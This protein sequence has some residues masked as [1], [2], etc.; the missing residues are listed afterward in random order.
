MIDSHCHLA[1][2]EFEADLPEVIARAKQAGGDGGRR[3]PGRAG[4][5]RIAAM[6]AGP[7]A[8]PEARAAVGVHPHQ[9]GEFA[10]DPAAAAR[11]LACGS[12][13][14]P[15]ARAV[16]EI[17]LDYHYDF[18]PREVQQAVFRAQLRLA[19][20]PRPAGRDP[21]PRGRRRHASASS[22]GIAGAEP[23]GVFHCFTG[24]STAAARAL[25]TGF[26]LSIPGIVTFPKAVEL[27]E[28]VADV[29]ADR[30]L[31]ET[32]SPY[33]APIPYPRQAQRAGLRRPGGRESLA[34]RA[35]GADA[36]ATASRRQ[37]RLRPTSTRSV[38]SRERPQSSA[39][40]GLTRLRAL[41]P[42][43]ALW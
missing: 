2:E 42:A 8:W 15:G 27:R 33:L 31:V 35:R 1:G 32:D 11:L 43:P 24:D 3:H 5:G 30:L 26:Y 9:A 29:P 34:G 28:A 39:L 14:C 16:G 7:R 22:R 41:T 40:Q 10:S 25:A 20:E 21:H 4:R 19:R 36:A 13:P 38:P 12:T 23:R 17:G 37:I 6:G 18:S